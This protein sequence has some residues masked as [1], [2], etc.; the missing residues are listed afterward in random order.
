MTAAH[1]LAFGHLAPRRWHG[2][3]G[4]RRARVVGL[5][6]DMI[7]GFLDVQNFIKNHPAE[8]AKQVSAMMAQNGAN[9]PWQAFESLVRQG[10]YVFQ[11]A[12]TSTL[13]SYLTR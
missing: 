4:S 3:V 5:A 11:P 1:P 6:L 2:S 13:K 9:A 7:A 12:F 10:R 8:A